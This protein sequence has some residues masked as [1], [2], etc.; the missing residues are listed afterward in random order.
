[1]ILRQ[2]PPMGVYEILF[3][4]ADATGKYMGDKFSQL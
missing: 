2:F 1:M 3:S 4:F